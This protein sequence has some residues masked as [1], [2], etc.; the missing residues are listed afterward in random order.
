MHRLDNQIKFISGFDC[1][2]ISTSPATC[3]AAALRLLGRGL[4]INPLELPTPVEVINCEFPGSH[5]VLEE[6]DA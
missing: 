4:I 1:H 5:L 2:S 6:V 3:L